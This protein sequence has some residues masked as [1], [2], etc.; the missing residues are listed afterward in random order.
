[1]YGHL[2]FFDKEPRN[3]QGKKDSIFNKWCCSN[4]MAACRRIHIDLYL[5][6]CTKLNSKW[7]KDLKIKPY[8]LNLVEEKVR[9]SL[10]LIDI[11]NS[12][13]DETLIA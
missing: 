9:N 12:F 10:E 13:L 2:S 5:P 11:E 1:M 7:S 8:T 4:W 6:P 3:T